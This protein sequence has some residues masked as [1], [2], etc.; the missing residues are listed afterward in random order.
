MRARRA[1]A[2]RLAPALTVHYDR[3]VSG[4]EAAMPLPVVRCS[5]AQLAS[6]VADQ[7][8]AHLRRV[9]DDFY[10]A[11]LTSRIRLHKLGAGAFEIEID[12]VTNFERQALADMLPFLKRAFALDEI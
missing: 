6:H 3:G 4:S 5:R 10:R 2:M 9:H 12:G 8:V 7:L 1:G 11:D